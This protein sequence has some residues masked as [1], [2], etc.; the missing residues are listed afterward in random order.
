MSGATGAQV[1][2]PQLLHELNVAMNIAF[3]ALYPRL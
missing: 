3:T 1:V 2:A